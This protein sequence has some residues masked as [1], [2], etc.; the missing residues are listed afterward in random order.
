MFLWGMLSAGE[1]H[2]LGR[3][4]LV[5]IG[6]ATESRTEPEAQDM[7]TQM[8]RELKE[9]LNDLAASWKIRTEP[10]LQADCFRSPQN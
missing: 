3:K 10:D 9:A 6:A 2:E 1:A 7:V 5:M 8:I 4:L